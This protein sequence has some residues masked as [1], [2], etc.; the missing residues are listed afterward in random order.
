M[1]FA[2]TSNFQMGSRG[3]ITNVSNN[4]S[5]NDPT[6]GT[7]QGTTSDGLIYTYGKQ[8]GFTLGKEVLDFMKA[9]SKGK[10]VAIAGGGAYAKYDI[11]V[12]GVDYKLQIDNSWSHSS[13]TCVFC[14]L[15]WLL[16]IT[17]NGTYPIQIIEHIT[18]GN[19]ETNNRNFAGYAI[20]VNPN[21][22]GATQSE[23]SQVM[24][25]FNKSISTF[26]NSFQWRGCVGY[27]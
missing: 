16:S 6:F 14:S 26:D 7:A 1:K 9:N 3:V 11:R 23:D 15:S 18:G 10:N 19:G 27:R 25:Y 21:Y 22:T 8:T 12:N 13:S 4:V 24:R 17:N 5:F 2:K 20:S